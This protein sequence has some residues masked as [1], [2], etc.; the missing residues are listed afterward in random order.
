MKALI[1]KDTYVIWR[2]MK[3]FLVMILLFCEEKDRLLEEYGIFE[4]SRENLDCLMPEAVVAR[5]ETRYGGVR[6]LVKR[7]LVPPTLELERPTVEDVILFT[8][9]GAKQS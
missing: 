5:E 3:Y 9:K 4:D 2:Q 6:A 8:V 7:D 1:L